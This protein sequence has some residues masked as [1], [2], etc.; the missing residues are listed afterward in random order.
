MFGLTLEQ[1]LG[2]TVFAAL[3]TTVGNL[4]ATVLTDFFFNRS[5]EQWK[6]RRTLLS[7]YRKYRDPMVLAAENLNLDLAHICE[8]YPP[9]YLRSEVLEGGPSDFKANSSDDPHYRRY[10][11]IS[12]VYRLCAFLGWLELYRQELTFLD[13]GRQ[14]ENRR[15]EEALAQ[16]RSDLADGQLNK[17]TD[18]QV[19]RDGLIFREEQRA[20]GEAMITSGTASRVVVGYGT[21]CTLFTRSASDESLGRCGWRVPSF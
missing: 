11:L 6:E 4:F 17:A 15:F 20:I 7:V 8:A 18:W 14:S 9:D 12:T 2:L 1:L 19:L 10:R 13:T 3:V 16:L 21:F 5:F